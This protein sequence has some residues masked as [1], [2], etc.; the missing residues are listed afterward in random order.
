MLS[1]FFLDCLVFPDLSEEFCSNN[2]WLKS[3]CHVLTHTSGYLPQAWFLTNAVILLVQVILQAELV[4]VF[5]GAILR[6]GRGKNEVYHGPIHQS[7]WSEA[8]LFHSDAIPKICS[9]VTA[10][11]SPRACKG[12]GKGTRNMS[13]TSPSREFNWGG[14]GKG[15][16]RTR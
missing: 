9:E 2:R 5:Q 6:N 7:C 3:S 1:D 16:I 11:S 12:N 4:F 8:E 13:D 10:L 14:K 15:Q